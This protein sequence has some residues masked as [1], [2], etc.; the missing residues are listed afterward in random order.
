MKKFVRILALTLTA[1]ILT[2]SLASCFGPAKDPEKAVESLKGDGYTAT[3][4]TRVQP[5]L[6]MIAG[7]KLD[8]VVSASKIDTDKD[9]NK[10]V[11]HVTVY[12]FADKDNAAKA[13]AEVE[14]YAN[15][16]KESED[17]KDSTWVGPKQSG[18]I[19]YYG[20]KAGVKAAK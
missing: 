6:F 15:E 1:L 14:K 19:I 10:T 2:V 18:K 20:T 9:G 3:L 12:Y 4:D 17:A 11:E 13:M 16:D 8:A 5:A 7:F